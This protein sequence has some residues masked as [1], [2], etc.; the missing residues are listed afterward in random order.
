MMIKMKIE[1]VVMDVKSNLPILILKDEKKRV[2]P[3][4]VGIFEAQAIA[5]AIEKVRIPRPLTHDLMVVLIEKF[6]AKITKVEIND[7]KSNTYIASITLKNAEGEEIK[8]DSRPSDAIALA[9]RLNASIY[10]KESLLVKKDA[11]PINNAEVQ[12]FKEML[13]KLAPNTLWK[14]LKEKI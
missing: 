3:I 12:H 14:Y 9:L 5:F 11:R 1:G 7:V 8:I 4:S 6:G 10:V 13:G 2:L